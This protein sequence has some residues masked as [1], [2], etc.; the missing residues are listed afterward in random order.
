MK[1]LL[2][3]DHG[4]RRPEAHAHLQALADRVRALLP[5]WSVHVAHL[6][7][8]TPSIDEG[9]AACRRDGVKELVVHPLFLAPGRH[10]SQDVPREIE[11]A[12]AAHPDLT[13]RTTAPLGSAHQLAELVA[14]LAR[15]SAGS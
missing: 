11:R 14:K 15:G 13:V 5:D 3:V 2:I 12:A 7:L 4:S 8:A 10:T 1:G 6:E 9:I